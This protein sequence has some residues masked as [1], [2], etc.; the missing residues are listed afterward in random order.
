MD[1]E[2]FYGHRFYS[3]ED[4]FRE[5]SSRKLD[6]LNIDTGVIMTMTVDRI[7]QNEASVW[8]ADITLK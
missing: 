8:C 2:W 3:N 4:L 1:A 7:Y 6:W 5:G